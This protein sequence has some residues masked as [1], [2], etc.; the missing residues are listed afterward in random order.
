MKNKHYRWLALIMSCAM[1]ITG[2]AKNSDSSESDEA[3]KT[4]SVQQTVTDVSN[5][6]SITE[7][8]TSEII[9]EGSSYGS[10]S[11]NF[12]GL[13]DPDF[14]EYLEDALY[15][16]LVTGIDTDK[17]FVENIETCYISKEYLDELEYNSQKN[18]F[19]GY[20]L[21]E[22]NEQFEGKR[23]VFTLSDDGE[24]IVE[25]FQEYDDTYIKALKNFAIGTGVILVCVTVSVAT[26]GTAPAVSLIFGAS[27]KMGT[28][29]ALSSGVLGGGV[30]GVKTYIQTGD[31]E[32]ALKSAAITGSKDYKFGA[33]SGAILGGGAEA[34]SLHGATL[35][36]LTMN[37]AATIQKQSKYP[38]DVIKQFNN[39]EQFEVCQNAGLTAEMVNGKTALIRN[40][41]L[42]YVDE[43]TG[44][45]NL[46]R[47]QNGYAALDPAT[48][49]PYELHHIGQKADSTLA[50]LTKAEHMQNGNNKIW[51]NLV[52][53][54][55]IDR[56]AFDKIRKAFWEDLAKSMV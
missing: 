45:T 29:S 34:I 9:D 42:N 15:E 11:L 40:I 56:P 53:E 49:L 33:I 20:T 10:E 7:K 26:G 19:F 27:A 36:G 32:K 38:L 47:M 52:S 28:I 30:D 1:A 48:G 17:Y 51:H 12:D 55:E 5:S 41:D 22:L 23:Y 50:I 3:V 14:S 4:E 46:Q 21:D 18:V 31:I 54:S 35:N 24:T 39:M 25:E 43:V 6:D 37:E 16:Q 8:Q 44:W 13:N 2:C